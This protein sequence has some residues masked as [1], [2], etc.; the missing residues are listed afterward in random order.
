MAS[1]GLKEVLK[2]N[3]Y[4]LRWAD[5]KLVFGLSHFYNMDQFIR[6][7]R[8]R[9]KAPCTLAKGPCKSDEVIC[10]IGKQSPKF[11][12]KVSQRTAGPSFNKFEMQISGP[13][14]EDRSR[15]LL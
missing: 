3:G 13:I 6:N 12:G 4:H 10:L 1:W 2:S 5:L 8:K 11:V 9:C 7:M 15:V 14:S